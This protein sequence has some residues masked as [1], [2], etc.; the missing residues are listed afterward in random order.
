MIITDELRHGLARLLTSP[1]TAPLAREEVE[2]SLF[3]IWLAWPT[4][5]PMPEE[6]RAG[7]SDPAAQSLPEL[8]ATVHR[9]G[10]YAHD[11]AAIGLRLPVLTLLM[12]QLGGARSRQLAGVYYV[13]ALFPPAS[14]VLDS[15]DPL[16]AVAGGCTINAVT[17]T[18]V[19]SPTDEEIDGRVFAV[20][21]LTRQAYDAFRA[22]EDDVATMSQA[23]TQF[24]FACARED[25]L[26]RDYHNLL[27]TVCELWAC[28]PAGRYAKAQLSQYL[29]QHEPSG[30]EPD[31]ALTKLF[32]SLGNDL[33]RAVAQ[34][35]TVPPSR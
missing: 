7:L 15:A 25:A 28:T 14:N 3:A 6:L 19:V 8:D 23:D 2:A 18:V 11:V 9:L 16:I 12:T 1:L 21:G 30:P 33:D 10:C 13:A 32:R 27:D 31:Q 20:C 35:W 26:R 4:F 34:G 22:V 29:G 17:Y 24:A 5:I